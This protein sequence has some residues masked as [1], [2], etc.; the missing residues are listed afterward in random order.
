MTTMTCPECN[1]ELEQGF[2]FSTKDGAFSFADE[3]P[4]SFKDAKNAPRF[5]T[6]HCTQSR[7]P[8]QRA[9]IAVPRLPP[10]HRYVLSVTTIPINSIRNPK[11]R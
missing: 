5:C 2:L 11:G 8:R 9:G 7:R 3:V 4:S 6:N 10:A 1:G